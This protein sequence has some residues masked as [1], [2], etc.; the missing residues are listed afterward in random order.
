MKSSVS[1]IAVAFLIFALTSIVANA[2]IRKDTVTF[3][4]NITV[5]GTVLKKG[6]Y[7][8]KFNDETKEL[9]LLKS[10]KVVAKVTAH[11][12]KADSTAKTTT[13]S[14]RTSGENREFVSITFG[15]SDERIVVSGAEAASN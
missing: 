13:F 9:S 8:V 1:R 2:K 12:E 11:I 6:N 15:G 5:N 4:S 10:G 3:V 14:T 7:D